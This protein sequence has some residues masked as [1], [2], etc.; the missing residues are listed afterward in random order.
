MAKVEKIT[1]MGPK[2]SGRRY[3]KKR[4]HRLRRRAEKRDPEKA[5]RRLKDLTLGW[6]D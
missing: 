5:P 4:T 2:G 3:E 1:R 6:G